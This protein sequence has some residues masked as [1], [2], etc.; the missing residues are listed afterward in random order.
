MGLTTK[1]KFHFRRIDIGDSIS[2]SN[3]VFFFFFFFSFFF[4][5]LQKQ[6]FFAWYEKVITHRE[7]G[8]AAK[9]N[10]EKL[11]VVI[12]LKGRCDISISRSLENSGS[13]HASKQLSFSTT[14]CLLRSTA[15]GNSYKMI[16]VNVASYALLAYYGAPD[17]ANDNLNGTSLS[18]Q[19]SNRA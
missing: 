13:K 4:F 16:C 1:K 8:H 12:S 5:F 2:F 14:F 3:R 7:I 6:L 10:E 19:N 17:N 15:K 9:A 18:N 11:V